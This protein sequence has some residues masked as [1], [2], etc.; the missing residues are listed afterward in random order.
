M[1]THKDLEVWQISIDL[2]DVVY[3]I[4]EPFPSNEQYGLVSQMRRCAISI[5]SNIAEG[6]GRNNKGELIHFIGIARGSL[7]ELET[8][9]IIS[10]RRGYLDEKQIKKI[11]SLLASI[12]KMLFR[13]TQSLKTT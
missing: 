1:G 5:P 3:D 7:A 12:S 6:C 11:D 13:L 2:V 4:T 8:Q 10:H 9:S